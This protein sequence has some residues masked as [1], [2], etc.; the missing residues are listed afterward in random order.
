VMSLPAHPL[1]DGWATARRVQA[2]HGA[3]L[4]TATVR[5]LCARG[6]GALSARRGG[7]AAGALN[8]SW[9]R[10]ILPRG[11]DA[12]RS[13]A[14]PVT[15]VLLL[16]TLTAAPLTDL[17]VVLGVACCGMRLNLHDITFVL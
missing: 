7:T 12:A 10:C 2:V 11:V 4:C 3:T 14:V 13:A 16:G 8:A 1:G 5:R 17:D 9:R 6:P 15:A